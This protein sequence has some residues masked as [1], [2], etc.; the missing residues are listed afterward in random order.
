MEYPPTHE[1]KER[2]F[3]SVDYEKGVACSECPHEDNTCQVDGCE[4]E[5]KWPDDF[6][7]NSNV[8]PRKFRGN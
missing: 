4:Q 3:R 2:I 8:T 6:K 7:F 1:T 5:V